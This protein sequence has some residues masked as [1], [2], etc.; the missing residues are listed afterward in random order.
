MTNRLPTA[1]KPR[2][3]ERKAHR[4][5]S[6]ICTSCYFINPSENVF[7][8]NCGSQLPHVESSKPSI[9]PLILANTL[10]NSSLLISRGPWQMRMD[11]WMPFIWLAM[12]VFVATQNNTYSLLLLG[13]G[14][15][16]ALYKSHDTQQ[17]IKQ[18]IP[19]E[20][21]NK[22]IIAY[23]P[24][25]T[26][27]RFSLPTGVLY[28]LSDGLYF[29]SFDSNEEISFIHIEISFT[30]TAVLKS[31]FSIFSNWQEI[32]MNNGMKDRFT[33]TV[34]N[35]G[36]WMLLMKFLRSELGKR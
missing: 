25:N 22:T 35:G 17:I 34:Q 1:A 27:S 11:L 30:D 33:F 8:Q 2:A 9:S 5:P 13:A 16:F 26:S 3:I 18:T 32:E 7:C 24:A 21:I 4:K 23:G 10:D 29:K 20:L 19:V 36:E 14:L 6:M 12:A 28:L 15:A 31:G